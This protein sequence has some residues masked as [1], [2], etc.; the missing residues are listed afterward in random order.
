[1]IRKA[2]I[3]VLTLGA[4]ATAMAWVWSLMSPFSWAGYRW[5]GVYEEVFACSPWPSR[6]DLVA[7][8]A[9]FRHA[10]LIDAGTPAP[11]ITEDIAGCMVKVVVVKPRGRRLP[12]SSDWKDTADERRERNRLKRKNF[13]RVEV[14]RLPLWAP[15]ILFAAYPTIAFIRGPLRRYRRRRKGLCIP[16]GYDLTGNV[17]GV[18]P[19]CGTEVAPPVRRVERS[20]FR[21]TTGRWDMDLMLIVAAIV[22]LT[23]LLLAVWW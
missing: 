4:I 19:E 11:T 5:P 1:M 18:C 7:G 9:Y 8:K 10:F 20:L 23:S 21:F 12:W 17:S 15:F 22:L 2:I 16:C 3:V 6:V 14:L 13:I